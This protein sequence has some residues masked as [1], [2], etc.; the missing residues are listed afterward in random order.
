[1]NNVKMKSQK[2]S[3]YTTFKWKENAC[4]KSKDVKSMPGQYYK[5]DWKKLKTWINGKAWIE[6][7]VSL[8]LCSTK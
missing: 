6:V 5:G 3:S 1:M 2:K 8:E 7:L 4:E